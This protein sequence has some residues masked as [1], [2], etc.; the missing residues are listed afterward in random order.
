MNK[1][2]NGVIIIVSIL[3]SFIC[4]GIGAFVLVNYN[5]SNRV[6]VTNTGSTIKLYASCDDVNVYASISKLE[7]K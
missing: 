1:N 3:I 6:I 4:G 2:N 7:Y 5:D